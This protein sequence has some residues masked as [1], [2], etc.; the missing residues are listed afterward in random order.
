MMPVTR[1]GHEWNP[2]IPVVPKNKNLKNLELRL[3]PSPSYG[4]IG[5]S[6]H[7]AIS[8]AIICSE[9]ARSIEC[10]ECGAT[11]SRLGSSTNGDP[12]GASF[13]IS[14]QNSSYFVAKCR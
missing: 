7:L 3:L 10:K 11:G 13:K 2:K 5:T 8:R 4:R 1:G 9:A 6:F 14:R 12:D